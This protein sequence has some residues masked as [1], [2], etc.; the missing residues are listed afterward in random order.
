[1]NKALSVCLRTDIKPKDIHNIF[2]WLNNENV[3]RYLNESPAACDGLLYLIDSVPSHM[4]TFHLNQ[5]GHF[6]LVCR[7]QDSE[8][9]G[10]I[11]F[12]N[13]PGNCYEVVYV[14]G[15]EKL[16]GKGLGKAALK[17]ALELAFFDK[18]VKAV[19]AKVHK[20]NS[21]SVRTA[22]SCGMR[23]SKAG[24]KATVFG[25]TFDEYIKKAVNE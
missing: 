3:V 15:E 8:S 20:K 17:K 4:L 7:S 23:L 14:I 16:W 9:V 1:M 6:F 2:E 10:F 18:R 19:Y 21:R 5:R 11:K 22:L 12:E 24:D 25:V 13:L